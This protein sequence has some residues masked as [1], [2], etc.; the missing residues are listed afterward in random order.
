[1]KINH[2]KDE[3]E[4]EVD[5]SPMIE[6]PPLAVNVKTQA[7]VAKYFKVSEA[8]VS[9]WFKKGAPIESNATFNLQKITAWK[10]LRV[11]KEANL[12]PEKIENLDP[13]LLEEIKAELGKFNTLA[14]VYQD[15]R[16]TIYAGI[17]GKLLSVAESILNGV[18]ARKIHKMAI[19]DQLK[20]LKDL[21]ASAMA[22]FEKERLEKGESTEN[23]ALI[24]KYIKEMK[25]GMED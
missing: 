17:G 21:V 18:D 24:V 22:L 20:G 7:E 3:A 5:D 4:I 9:K 19:R 10:M 16:E 13:K 6:Q 2:S 8:A 23:V 15:K 1:M 25:D 11:A 14:E 12:I